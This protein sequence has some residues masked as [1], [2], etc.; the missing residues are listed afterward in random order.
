MTNPLSKELFIVLC[1]IVCGCISGIWYDVFKALR[2]LGFNSKAA[3]MV[4]DACFWIGETAIIFYMLFY[5]NNAKLRWYEIFFVIFGFFSYRYLLSEAVVL[6]LEKIM[7]FVAKTVAL[8]V[9]TAYYPVKKTA[10][11]AKHH[12]KNKILRFI[13]RILR[14]Q[15]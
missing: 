15:Q 5:A 4:Q 12:R 10:C 13:R 8:A 11:F 9:K 1:C 3:V 7:M 6:I 14:R 2:K